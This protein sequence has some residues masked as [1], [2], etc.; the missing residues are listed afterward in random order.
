MTQ[1]NLYKMFVDYGRSG[2]IEGLFAASEED[3]TGSYGRDVY[4]GEVLGKHSDVCFE[5][6]ESMITKLD[7]SPDIVQTIV[8]AV[9]DVTLSGY[10]PLEYIDDGDDE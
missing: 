7:V 4:L 6:E 3:I 10:N 5:L 8:A 2:E 1:L 9:G